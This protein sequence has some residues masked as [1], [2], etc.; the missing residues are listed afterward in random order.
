MAYME[1]MNKKKQASEKMSISYTATVLL[2]IIPR[3]S[4][5]AQSAYSKL[6]LKLHKCM[7]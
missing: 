4:H 3:F 6:K 7:L 1:W 5:E 2:L